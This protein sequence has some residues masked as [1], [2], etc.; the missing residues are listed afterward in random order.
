MSPTTTPTY[1]T[2][3]WTTY[4]QAVGVQVQE[5]RG[6]GRDNAGYSITE[7]A[8]VQTHELHWYRYRI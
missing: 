1:L 6:T 5:L 7:V 3:Y 8:G 4:Q 2:S